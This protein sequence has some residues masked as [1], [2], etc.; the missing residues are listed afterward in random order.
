MDSYTLCTF[1]SVDHTPNVSTA[2]GINTYTRTCLF[3]WKLRHCVSL[4]LNPLSSSQIQGNTSKWTQLRLIQG[5]TS[6]KKFQWPSR[7]GTQTQFLIGILGQQEGLFGFTYNL[8]LFINITHVISF[9]YCPILWIFGGGAMP[10]K[11]YI[12]V[13]ILHYMHVD[14]VRYNLV[15]C[16]FGWNLNQME[17]KLDKSQKYNQFVALLTS[18]RA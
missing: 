15:I 4:A 7:W 8:Y 13:G 18:S 1:P 5:S 16:T 6:C 14:T 9:V 12:H 3:L 2:T 17:L 11:Y 10:S